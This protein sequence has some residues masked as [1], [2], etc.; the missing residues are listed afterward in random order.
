MNSFRTQPNKNAVPE[1]LWAYPEH[2]S[3]PASHIRGPE[4]AAGTAG[5]ASK[6]T[7]VRILIA[8]DSIT[9]RIMLEAILQGAGYRVGTAVDGMEAFAMLRAEPFDLLV[10][11]V[12]M[13]RLDGFGLTARIR[14]DKHLA[15]LP[16]ILLTALESPEDRERGI[17][18]GANAYLIKSSFGQ[19]DLLETIRQLL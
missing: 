6:Q 18:V 9:A 13:P 17:A 7:A 12:E 3:R 1:G 4:G 16:V 19:R 5:P 15:G 11:D 2:P 14:A 8:E 10:S